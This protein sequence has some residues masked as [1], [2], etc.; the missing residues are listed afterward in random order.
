MQKLIV[1][2][3]LVFT[4]VLSNDLSS[5]DV[6][7]PHTPEFR[8][9]AERISTIY[10]L[11]LPIHFSVGNI[12]KTKSLS[13]LLEARSLD[14]DERDLFNTEIYL[15]QLSYVEDGYIYKQDGIF[16]N[17][18]KN[19]AQLFEYKSDVFEFKINPF[20]DFELGRDLENDETI[21]L[22]KRGLEFF[23]ALDDKFYFYS[24]IHENQSNFLSYIDSFIVDKRAIPGQG[25]FK[26]FDSSL[27]NFEKS[28]DYG[29]A[30][31]YL[32]YRTSKHTQLEL[33]HG[34]HFL[35]NGMRSLLLSEFANNYFYLKFNVDVWKIHYQSIFAELGAL[36]SLVTA[37]NE[38]LTKK[39]MATHYLSIKATPRLEIGL[40]ESVIFARENNFEFQYLNPVIL[41][42]T[43]EHFID[44]PDNVLLGLNINWHAWQNLRLYGQVMFDEIRRSQLFSGSGWWGN[45]YGIQMGFK[46]FNVLNIPT[47]DIQ[48][49]MNI[50]RPFTY[51]HFRPTTLVPEYSV[52]SY[53]HFNQ[54]LAH[55]LGSNFREF[56]LSLK[57]QAL[58]RLY[59]YSR[60]IYASKGQNGV[61]NIGADIL[62]VNSS[63]LSNFNNSLLQGELETI[64][65]F[66]V[67]L[68]YQLLN[69]LFLESE[70]FIRNSKGYPPS[71]E[72]NTF[73]NFSCRYNIRN[74]QIDY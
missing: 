42:R 64:N 10:H 41:Y 53:S 38:L 70:L 24:S 3:I 4:S 35:G 48:G 72:N 15:E 58:K 1:I 51:S 5:Q 30:M 27:F 14:L 13:F 60:Y 46:Y 71:G 45:K 73:L 52:S 7:A 17:L 23:G 34:K 6:Y 68:S 21:F 62:L 36:S 65:T 26:N 55:P 20:F 69:N 59:I 56:I 12:P 8:Q 33:G 63:R 67:K 61:N 16:N 31:A 44:S 74:T 47:L 54:S 66:H 39:Y 50:V 2:I 25:S 37:Q 19:A 9:F 49:E 32:G 29:N 22:N 28:Y 40:F 57:Y 11:D 43:V 18:Y